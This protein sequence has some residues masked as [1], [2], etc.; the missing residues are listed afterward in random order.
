MPLSKKQ[1]DK[2][3]KDSIKDGAAFSAMDGITSTYTTPFALA[4]GANDAQVGILS[5]IPNL[6]ITLSQIFAGKYIE[7]RGRK[8]VAVSLSLAQRLIWLL[9]AFIPLFIFQGSLF[10]FIFLIVLIQVILNFASTAWSAWMGNLVP[11]NIRGSYFGKRNAIV[12]VFSFATAL[13]AGWL[14]GLINGLIGFSLVFF[15]AFIFGLISYFYLTKIPDAGYKQE[16]EK[17]NNN[18]NVFKFIKD[19]KKYSNFRPFTIHMSLLSFAVNIASPFFTVYML[20]VMKIGYEWYGIV[21]ATEIFARILMQRYW[22]R[23]SDK[24]GDRTVMSLCNILI[25]FYPL[26]FLFASSVLQL[27]LISIF[28]GIA[29]SGFDLTS[30]NYLLD[31]TP[32]EKRPS[33]IAN[34]KIYVGFALFLGP[35]MG[36]FL[37]QYLTNMTFFWLGSLQIIFLLS[38]ILRGVVTAYGVPKLKEVRAKRVLPVS[39]VAVKA[40]AVYPVRGITQDIIYFQR[41]IEHMEKDFE[42]RFK[43]ELR[44]K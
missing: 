38:F 18:F 30:F 28:S 41:G 11:E 13:I 39:D 17:S 12:S 32:P 6:F 37:S 35:L 7:K 26:L 43:K 14:L 44:R 24:F 5:S 10:L 16:N 20:S 40:F 4:L 34:Y 9:I 2:A 19:L 27:M 22:G 25:V 1:L 31:V 15:L 8:K 21:V 42:K 33:Y 36:G 29:W 23:L 3:L